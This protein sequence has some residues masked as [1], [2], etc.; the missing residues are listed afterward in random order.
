[1][2]DTPLPLGREEPAAENAELVKLLADWGVTVEQGPGARSQ[3][4]RPV[5]RPRSGSAAGHR[6]TNRMPITAP[7]SR[8]VPTAFPLSRSLDVKS[9]DKATATKLFGTGEESVA[10]T[11]VP[12]GRRDR[13]EEGQER[14]R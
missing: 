12:A 2:L 9:G 3:R 11:G 1:M 10:V 6:A 13:S 7:L 8:G 5:V 14:V 4:R